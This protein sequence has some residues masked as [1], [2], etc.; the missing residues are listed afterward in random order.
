MNSEEFRVQRE[1]MACHGIHS[2][3]E[4]QMFFLDVGFRI[5]SAEG[6]SLVKQRCLLTPFRDMLGTS[7]SMRRALGTRVE[8]AWGGRAG[9]KITFSRKQEN[10][11]TTSLWHCSWH[12]PKAPLCP[13]C[14]LHEVHEHGKEYESSDDKTLPGP[15][16]PAPTLRQQFSS[17]SLWI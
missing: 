6:S 13:I 5:A 16:G 15:Q 12:S 11:P 14:C 7:L 4:R 10:L 17:P 1:F 2:Q 3:L 8:Q 9:T